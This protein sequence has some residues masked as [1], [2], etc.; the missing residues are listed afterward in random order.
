MVINKKLCFCENEFNVNMKNLFEYGYLF[1]GY[2]TLLVVLVFICIF[3]PVEDL[4]V[5]SI[6]VAIGTL[7]MAVAT[8]YM[9]SK[10]NKTIE[11]AK[12]LWLKENDALLDISV[13]CYGYKL[14]LIIKNIGKITAKNIDL[15]FNSDF[16]HTVITVLSD[17][18][19]I[20]EN[21]EKLNCKIDEELN[22][23][24]KIK[25]QPNEVKQIYLIKWIDICKVYNKNVMPEL[26]LI[27][28]GYYDGYEKKK[29]IDEN[30]NIYDSLIEQMIKILELDAASEKMKKLLN[31]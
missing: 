8:F 14:V 19:K 3:V 21:R 20:S 25:L 5:S 29:I 27:I 1:Y 28:S 24:N 16:R 2:L 9:A 10:S 15:K 6:V 4:D 26:E 31:K 18:E 30:F 22:N 17:F 7:A 13:E 12:E 23:L 11:Q